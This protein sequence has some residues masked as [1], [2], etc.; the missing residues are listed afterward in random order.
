MLRHSYIDNRLGRLTVV[1]QGNHLRGIYFEG[2]W[3]HPDVRSFGT[4]ISSTEDALFMETAQQFE[5]YL[6]SE[7][8][9]FDLPIE[10]AGDRFHESVWGI[11]KEIPYGQTVSYG[12]IAEELGNIHLARRV[13]Q[14]VGANPLSV[15]IPCHRV[16]GKDGK[17]TGYAGGIERKQLLLEL[18][19]PLGLNRLW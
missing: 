6:S 4:L 15:I 1:A 8:R 10:T 7:R 3:T 16:L 14:A 2:H 18:E 11:L 17:I 9:S 12:E 5:Q 19:E 13:G